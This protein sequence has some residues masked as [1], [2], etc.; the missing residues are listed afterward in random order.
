MPE[1]ASLP[2]GLFAI[3]RQV[4]ERQSDCAS[5]MIRFIETLYQRR[6]LT[7]LNWDIKANAIVVA[8]LGK[9][10]GIGYSWSKRPERSI[11]YGFFVPPS[12]SKLLEMLHSSPLVV[13]TE[14]END[15]QFFNR[16]IYAFF[17]AISQGATEMRIPVQY[18]YE[19]VDDQLIERYR[20]ALYSKGW[21]LNES[22]WWKSLHS[23]SPARV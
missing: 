13:P 6:D 17:V 14:K 7:A 16:Q 11:P 3:L 21:R 4:S 23:P 22:L 15:W 19:N 18:P 12:D 1:L 8:A 2:L 10:A 9:F 5:V 20:L